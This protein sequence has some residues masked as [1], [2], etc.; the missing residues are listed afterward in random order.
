MARQSP[1]MY[2]QEPRAGASTPW[3]RWQTQPRSSSRCWERRLG[4][5]NF[6]HKVSGEFGLEEGPVL[7]G[8]VQLGVGHAAMH[9]LA[10][11]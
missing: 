7:E 4:P 6:S 9:D 8:A 2:A 1:S 5:Q 10:Q 11:P 3:T